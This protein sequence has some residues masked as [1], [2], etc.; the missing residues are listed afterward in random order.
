MQRAALY[1]VVDP[2]V[3]LIGLRVTVKTGHVPTVVRGRVPLMSRGPLLRNRG[4][5]V[6]GL[7][8]KEMPD[9]P[10]EPGLLTFCPARVIAGVT[11]RGTGAS[12][13]VVPKRVLM[14]PPIC[15]VPQSGVD[16]AE[17][18]FRIALVDRITRYVVE[19]GKAHRSPGVFICSLPAVFQPGQVGVDRAHESQ[20]TACSASDRIWSAWEGVRRS[21]PQITPGE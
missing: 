14:E 11:R 9:A 6:I 16:P 3:A 1:P 4:P 2:A 5:P 13:D 20:V 15:G 21:V 12:Q 18:L 8:A 19:V 10:Q 17:R 7:N